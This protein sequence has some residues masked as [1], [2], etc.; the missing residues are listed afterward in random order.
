M[1]IKKGDLAW[2]C[3]VVLH[4]DHH[5]GMEGIIFIPYG[6]SKK[7]CKRILKEQGYDVKSIYLSIY[8]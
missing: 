1:N 2:N 8:E 6:Y 7:T 3:V 4:G 5:E